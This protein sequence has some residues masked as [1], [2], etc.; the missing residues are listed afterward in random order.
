MDGEV[1][2]E[3]SDMGE[4]KKKKKSEKKA[5]ANGFGEAV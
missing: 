2:E 4:V 1:N 5:D 3:I